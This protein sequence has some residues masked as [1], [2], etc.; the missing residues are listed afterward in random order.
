MMNRVHRY[1]VFLLAFC[2]A[3]AFMPGA[4][5]AEGED[6]VYSVTEGA[7]TVTGY[8][9]TDAD[10][11]VPDTLGGCPV[12]GIAAGAFAGKAIESVTLPETVESVGDG[13]FSGCAALARAVFRGPMPEFGDGVFTGS[14]PGFTLYRHNADD[15]WAGYS[16]TGVGTFVGLTLKYQDG[17]TPDAVS[18]ALLSGGRLSE[19]E[20]PSRDGFAFTGWYRTADCAGTAFDFASD[21]VD[22]DITLFAGWEL[23][24]LG[25]PQGLSVAGVT[26]DSV[27]LRW[28]AVANADSY[29]VLR[30]AA[31]AGPYEEAGTVT[32]TEFEDRGLAT[33]TSYYYK[34]Q[35]CH[36]G[37]TLPEALSGAIAATPR[38]SAPGSLKAA[39]S[40]YD[41][42]KLTWG[43]VPGANGYRIY[44][45]ASAAGTYAQ[46]GAVTG[47]AYENTGLATG[48]RYYYK[49][50]AYRTVGANTVT[51]PLT[52]AVSA[53]PVFSAPGNLKAASVR[54]DQIK[55]T[56]NAVPGARYAVYRAASANGPY[57]RLVFTTSTSYTGTGLATGK[58]YYYK[59]RSYRW[60]GETRVYGNTTAAVSAAPVFSA[61]G[62]LKAA[63]VRYD[64]IKLT[65][66]A[67]PGARYAVYRAAS[68]NGPY[69]R[70]VFTTSTSYTG[71]GLATGKTYY[72]KVRSYRWAGSTRVYGNTTAAVSAKPVFSAPG[73]CKAVS[74]RYD[75]IK[76][77]WNA[78]PGAGGYSVY[79][80]TSS[81]GAYTPLGSTSSLSYTN[82]GLTTGQPY[83]YKIKPYRM[84]GKTPVYGNAS[85][86][87]TGVPVF[88]APTGF[89]ASSG[90][91][92]RINLAWNAV[93]GA[94]GYSVYRATSS[95]GAYTHWTD[96]ASTRATDYGVTLNKA[97][98]YKIK[99]Y[100]TAGG[101]RVYGN[102]T[103]VKG[104]AAKAAAPGSIAAKAGS[105]REIVVTWSAV[106]GATGYELYRK[107]TSAGAYALVRELTANCGADTGLEM[108]AQYYYKVRAFRVADGQR[109]Y[110]GYTREVTARPGANGV[111]DRMM[112]IAAGELGYEEIKTS[113]GQEDGW[114]KYA[115]DYGIDK[116]SAWCACFVSW[117]AKQV[118]V[119]DTLI[120]KYAWVLS[121]K[122][123]YQSRGRYQSVSSSY[124]P[125][126]GD[127]IFF[128]SVGA[129]TTSGNHT[130]LV[131]AYDPEAQIIYTIEG[132]IGDKVN[133][134]THD[135]H[136][137]YVVGFGVNGGYSLGEVPTPAPRNFQAASASYDSIR[138]SWASA[139]TGCTYEVYRATSFQGTYSRVATTT[140][141]NYTNTGLKTGTTYYYKLRAY[142]TA[143]SQKKYSAYTSYVS[144]YARPATPSNVRAAGDES[145]ITV[146][147]NA[148]AGATGYEVGRATAANGTFTPI[149]DVAAIS[150]TDAA[151]APGTAY[152]YRVRAYHT[153]DGK[154]IYGSYSPAAAGQRPES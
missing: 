126:K 2:L 136:S 118:G 39:S 150:Y 75:Q 137:G 57:T 67:V 26:Y 64:Q 71:T 131:E 12:T 30:A 92:D 28:N 50:L 14:A 38:L 85:G 41:S 90:G 132:N 1:I 148:V 147:W 101:T 32:G 120:P 143:G 144:A 102:G 51:G 16:A 124:V 84:A 112:T 8:A 10:P 91:F 31:A 45:A 54:Y 34:V 152:Y 140:S 33:G 46:V 20:A 94:G 53:A 29:R 68:A 149:K 154:K 108:G 49:V 77:T 109:Y 78:V 122:A 107:K 40:R 6:F 22:G 119:R 66:N 17:A 44:R 69:T 61:P 128:H 97:Y 4:A 114:T 89:T 138:L 145:G 80:A 62:N 56:W 86:A 42:I 134:A 106:G 115:I 47:T 96:T 21:T 27:R 52:G 60:S 43:A 103:S 72:Y 142:R 18:A 98:Y 125:R 87:I 127:V 135:R 123:W 74:A 81:A 99:P 153:E 82:T 105:D 146:S 19:P 9:G 110:S 13:A 93:P 133:R 65:W 63:S 11:A 48:V 55:L 59:V 111:L 88:T 37:Q 139:G 73:N 5:L 151:C 141:L 117:C 76:L 95:A 79:R 36:N 7:A 35:A 100:R 15:S 129:S 130:G 121:G 83:Y 23:R 24:S 25:A 113:P 104:A 116:Y 70:L 58:T 3:F